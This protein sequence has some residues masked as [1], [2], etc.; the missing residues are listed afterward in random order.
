VVRAVQIPP[1]LPLTNDTSGDEL[2]HNENLPR[3]RSHVL[4]VGAATGADVRG[5]NFLRIQ[6]PASVLWNAPDGT[7]FIA[8]NPIATCSDRGAMVLEQ[9]SNQD[10]VSRCTMPQF[11]G[12][13]SGNWVQ[14][15]IR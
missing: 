1:G 3:F 13:Q 6:R 10:A 14:E 7:Y 5:D 15:E 11:C 2:P 4:L 8:G 9:A 12:R